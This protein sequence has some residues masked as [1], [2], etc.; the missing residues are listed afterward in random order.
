MSKPS[1]F[2]SRGH[3]DDRK[4]YPV[5]DPTTNIAKPIRTSQYMGN[6]REQIHQ[7]R[8]QR[9]EQ[10]QA[11][12][13][14]RVPESCTHCSKRM[15]ECSQCIAVSH[16]N[17][18]VVLK[19]RLVKLS[20]V[21]AGEKA[22][23]DLERRSQYFY[24]MYKE[25]KTV[26]PILVHQNPETGKYIIFDGHARF[27]ALKRLYRETGALPYAPVVENAQAEPVKSRP[28]ASEHGY[29]QWKGQEVTSRWAGSL[30][31]SAEKKEPMIPVVENFSLGDIGRGIK[32]AAKAIGHRA[33][34]GAADI[35]G[36][37]SHIHFTRPK[38]PVA[39]WKYRTAK[40]PRLK[41]ARSLKGFA[42][43]AE[44]A[45]GKVKEFQTEVVE[46]ARWFALRRDVQSPN[47]NI[48]NRAMRTI[49]SKFPEHLAEAQALETHRQR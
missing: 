20:D 17:R 10:S 40:E 24:N 29:E 4:V 28:I 44:A 5:Y 34:A 48:R 8:M 9:Y 3:G 35:K 6:S 45:K 38:E 33:K 13:F 21:R 26:P 25:G 27:H 15:D 41:I 47:A 22:P 49:A 30:P 42:G 19:L 43:K 37:A 46:Q 39:G 36:T 18:D 31:K 32:S 11:P 23:V 1:G 12:T 2:R 16:P 7:L 14:R